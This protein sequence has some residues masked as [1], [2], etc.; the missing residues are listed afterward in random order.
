MAAITNGLSNGDLTLEE[1]S[2]VMG[3]LESYERAIIRN[4]HVLE[5]RT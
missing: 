1:A 3:F 2:E 4:D 5:L